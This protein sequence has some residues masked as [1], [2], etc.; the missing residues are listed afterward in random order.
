MNAYEQLNEPKKILIDRESLTGIF[1]KLKYITDLDIKVIGKLNRHQI[2][3]HVFEADV[4]FVGYKY[5]WAKNIIFSLGIKVIPIDRQIRNYASQTPLQN[6]ASLDLAAAIVAQIDIIV[7]GQPSIYLGQSYRNPDFN[8][9]GLPAISIWSFQHFFTW[10]ISV[11]ENFY[12]LDK[13]PAKLNE[14]LDWIDSWIRA[15]SSRVIC[16]GNVLSFLISLKNEKHQEVLASADMITAAGQPIVRM[17]NKKL[18]GNQPKQERISDLSLLEGILT[19]ANNG[20]R[21][22]FFVVGQFCQ[23]WEK[24][25]KQLSKKIALQYPN[26]EAEY[27]FLLRGETLDDLIDRI[28]GVGLSTR[29]SDLVIMAQKTPYQEQWMAQNKGRIFAPM[30]GVGYSLLIFAELYPDAPKLIQALGFEWLV[31]FWEFPKTRRP[32][33][34][35]GWEIIQCWMMG[36][37]NCCAVESETTRDALLFWQLM[38]LDGTPSL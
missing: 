17:M 35:A 23:P 19:R 1:D 13:T 34:K 33:L 14:Y 30:I 15:S 11:Y 22:V 2:E 6:S 25:S 8:L 21:K 26:I 3:L 36:K 5:P 29:K 18:S 16:S 7:A 20:H 9:P 27:K 32:Y 38:F 37:I 28:N 12:Q 4:D 10:L 24:L 31:R